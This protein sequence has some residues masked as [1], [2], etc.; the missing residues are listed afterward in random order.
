MR[1][2]DEA[3][4]AQIAADKAWQPESGKIPF[5]SWYAIVVL[6]MVNCFAAMDRV[7]LSILLEMIKHDLHLTDAQLGMVSGFAFAVFYVLLGLPLAWVADH[8]SR[9]KLV[10]VCLALWSGMTAVTGLA[11]SYSQLFLARMGVGVGEAGSHPPSHS[12][13]GQYFPRQK[14]ALGI[15][16]FNAG[17]ALGGAGGMALIGVLGEQLGWRAALQIVG[18][19]GIPLAL[20][21]YFT[22]QEPVRPP[23]PPGTQDSA[24]ATIKTLLRRRAFVHLIFAFA[25]AHVGTNG[26][27]VWSPAFLMRSFGMSMSEVGAWL[28][29][30]SAAFAVF[31]TIAGGALASWLLPR[32]PRWE[33]WM[34]LITTTLCVPI[35]VMMAFSPTAGFA[36]AAKALNTLVGGM[37]TGVTMAAVQ[38]FAEPRQ[39]ATAVALTLLVSALLG[40]GAGPYVIGAT[41]TALEPMLGIE[42]LRYALLVTP[43]MLMWAIAHYALSA[44]GALR[45]RVN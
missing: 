35:F 5:K 19:M 15:G 37:G 27:S 43:V 39:R 13:I 30:I 28:G 32:D 31:G 40:T 18:V 24:L 1:L 44:R 2:S 33:I 9:V 45:D 3:M 17:A 25:I 26:F 11:Q 22:L 16:I 36:L 29:G 41:S 38:S 20:L 7:G 23:A 14:R 6:A 34:P 42:S 8:Y 21:I 4:T 12:L 10:S